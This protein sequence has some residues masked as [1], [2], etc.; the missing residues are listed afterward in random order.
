MF[1]TTGE[2]RTLTH[3]VP[4]SPAAR[5][6]AW[7]TRI[8]GAWLQKVGETHVAA[9]T[10]VIEALEKSVVDDCKECILTCLHPEVS[11]GLTYDG[12]PQVNLDQMNPRQMM[13]PSFCILAMEA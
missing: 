6:R 7:R 9:E 11:H 10:D 3:I 12:I 1:E 8:R 5:I 2:R 4:S 13:D